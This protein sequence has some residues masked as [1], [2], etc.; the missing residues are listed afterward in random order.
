MDNRILKVDKILSFTPDPHASD[1]YLTDV[2]GT[3]RD[4][5]INLISKLEQ[6]PQV[7]LCLRGDSKKNLSNH[8]KFFNKELSKIFIVGLK[9]LSNIKMSTNRAYIHYKD[10]PKNLIVEIEQLVNKVNIEIAAK[11]NRHKITGRISPEFIR[12]LENQ[13]SSLLGK[14][15]L[16]FLSFL[17][18][19][20][21]CMSFK[22]YSP[23]ISL[24][25]GY[26]KYV[27]ARKFALERCPHKK[28]ILFLYCLNS[29]WSYYIKSIDF[30]KELKK[31]NIIWYKDIH[32]EIMLINGMYPHYL[33]GV[34][35]VE[36][37]KNPKFVINPWLYKMLLSNE[38]YD[39]TKGIQVDQTYFHSFAETL[40]YSNFFFHY[41]NDSN[42]YVSE[43][44][45]SNHYKVYR[46]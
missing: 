10:D 43:L 28:G 36:P 45:Q 37:Y 44:N 16:F 25:Y 22:K 13:D 32:K 26:R 18:N 12:S 38:K 5:L 4:R 42:A 20:G 3:V 11:P 19:N 6:I 33:L 1:Y 29:G 2:Y 9:S 39:Y 17:H 31:F 21:K 46:P 34:F 7:Y 35:E 30:T 41:I 14:W 23:F 27:I 15:K 40:G 8:D 24:T